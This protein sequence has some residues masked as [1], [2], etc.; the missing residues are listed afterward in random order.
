MLFP[1]GYLGL[2]APITKRVAPMLNYTNGWER[3]DAGMNA[4]ACCKQYSPE[5]VQKVVEYCASAREGDADD[6]E[7]SH[8]LLKKGIEATTGAATH[9]VTDLKV[10][11]PSH[12]L[13]CGGVLV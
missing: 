9:S 7:C 5:L 6:D 2:H 8:A 4:G 1:G 13:L 3:D 11:C 10:A 12:R